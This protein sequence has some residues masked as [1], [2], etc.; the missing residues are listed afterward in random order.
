VIADQ[1]GTLQRPSRH[2]NAGRRNAEHHRQEF[3]G[4]QKG[5]EGIRS[6]SLAAIGSSAVPANENARKRQL[7]RCVEKDV[8]VASS[9][10]R[11][12]GSV[13][14]LAKKSAPSSADPARHLDIHA[15]RCLVVAQKHRQADQSLIANGADLRRL[16]IAIVHTREPTPLSMKCTNSI[17]SSAL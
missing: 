1:T 2:R 5:I 17:R 16:T 11:F 4:Q 12:A 13:R 9:T 3:V 8:R 6:C 15:G 14:V 10:V 7:G